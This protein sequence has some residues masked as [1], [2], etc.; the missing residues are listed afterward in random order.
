MVINLDIGSRLPANCTSIGRVLLSYLAPAAL[1]EH[2]GR[3]RLVKHT[4]KTLVTPEALK[5]E[6]ARVR[7]QGYALIDEELEIG[8]RTIAVPILNGAGQAT[9]GLSVGAH[10]ARQSIPD[11]TER[12]LPVLKDAAAELGL[13][14]R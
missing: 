13:L 6:L 14:V 9:A 1:D 11:L 5:A 10:V 2:L 7:A 8:L 12:V 4:P 3:V